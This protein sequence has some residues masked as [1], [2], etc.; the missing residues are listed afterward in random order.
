MS[1][2]VI[3]YFFFPPTWRNSVTLLCFL[4]VSVS[5]SILSDCTSAAVCHKAN[6]CTGILVGRFYLYKCFEIK[7]PVQNLFN[8]LPDFINLYMYIQSARQWC[9]SSI[10]HNP[11]KLLEHVVLVEDRLQRFI[12]KKGGLQIIISF[13]IFLFLDLSRL[14]VE[15]EFH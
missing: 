1:L 8:L 9:N 5:D 4:C 2:G 11:I 3:F 14:S 15:T 12:N 7:S 6:T 13:I 10:V